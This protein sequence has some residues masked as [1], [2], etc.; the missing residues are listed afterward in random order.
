MLLGFFQFFIVM[1]LSKKVKF[2][3]P[4]SLRPDFD[5]SSSMV[6]Q[7]PTFR[8][9]AEAYAHFTRHF[10][11]DDF[12]DFDDDPDSPPE[13]VSFPS[14]DTC[15]LIS[16]TPSYD[17]SRSSEPSGSMKDGQ[18]AGDE[19]EGVPATKGKEPSSSTS[20]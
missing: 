13:I 3:E 18:R 4:D 14:G 6:I 17:G 9:I 11:P 16:Y 12:E 8:T 5:F 20:E 15:D 10:S 7:P 19:P 2:V 1:R